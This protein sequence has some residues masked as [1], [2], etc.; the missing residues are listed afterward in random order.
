[1]RPGRLIRLGEHRAAALRVS[2]AFRGDA[3]RKFLFE[4]GCSSLLCTLRPLRPSVRGPVSSLRPG[5]RAVLRLTRAVLSQTVV[6]ILSFEGC[7]LAERLRLFS[8]SS[9]LGFQLYAFM[10]RN[11]SHIAPIRH[12]FRLRVVFCSAVGGFL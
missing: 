12:H 11:G 3:V 8:K 9:G 2:R 7:L 5:T 6:T 10:A 4:G 1:M